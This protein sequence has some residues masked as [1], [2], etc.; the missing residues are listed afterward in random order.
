M[1]TGT[2]HY[3]KNMNKKLVLDCIR[4][5]APLSRA[6][7]SARL[8][9]SKPTISSVVEE[10]MDE[11]WI[12]EGGSGDSTSQGG[13]KPIH[14]RFNEEAGYIIGVDIGGTKVSAGITNLA[15]KMVVQR[16]FDTKSSLAKGL[17]QKLHSVVQEMAIEA[18]IDYEKILGMGSGVP[19][20][21]DVE[22][23]KVIEAPSLNWRNYPFKQEAERIFDLPV[24]VDNDVN[25][26][27]LGERWLGVAK[28]KNNILL[29]AVGTG[30]G[31][32]IIMDGKLYRGSTWAAGEIGYMVTDKNAARRQYNP[33]Y[34]G[35]G[36]L[37]SHAGGAS[38]AD[39][40]VA[41]LRDQTGHPLHN[42]SSAVTAED[43]FN[44]AMEGDQLAES[45]VDEALEHLGFSIINAIS[46]FNPEMVILGGGV[47]K[48]GYWF[49]GRIQ[50]MVNQF[51]P[52]RT[53][54]SL[55][56]LGDQVG[57]LGAV[58]LFLKEYDGVLKI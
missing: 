55:T 41:L 38:I 34:K 12:Y 44:Y 30:I 25:V 53:Q 37:E 17:I 2:L 48:S 39:K 1:E 18:N 56:Q 21:T 27:V 15:G 11:G 35:Y 52:S 32:G 31:C 47:S 14:L 28:D 50:E 24:F 8:N 49:L 54:V 40:M 26:A 9:I 6:E 22:K 13:R 4:E 36:F 7:V 57:V 43:V 19:G 23:G 3:I 46:I 45:I 20:I 33:I 10:L 58:S 51:V 16:V 42:K 5:Q 29:I